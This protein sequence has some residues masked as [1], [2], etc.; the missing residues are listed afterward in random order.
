MDFEGMYSR[1]PGQLQPVHGGAGRAAAPS[2]KL[3]TV[4]LSAKTSDTR[5]GWAAAHDY[6]AHQLP[7]WTWRC[8]CPTDIAPPKQPCPA[9]PRRWHGWR[10]AWISPCPRFPARSSFWA[11]PC[12]AT[13]GTRPPGRPAGVVTLPRCH[14]HGRAASGFRVEYDITQQ[15]ARFHYVENGNTREVWFEDQDDSGREGSAGNP[16]WARRGGHLA[17]GPRRPAGVAG[18]K[19][20]AG[21]EPERQP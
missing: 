13:T 10:P 14:R 15:S 1:G 3:V 6:A 2:G 21:P 7:A 11:C 17:A 8:S 19:R 4:A 5:T 9:R 18:D 16:P 20:A 12:T